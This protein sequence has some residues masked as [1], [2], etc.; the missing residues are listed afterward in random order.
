MV[1]GSTLPKTRLTIVFMLVI[2]SLAGSTVAYAQSDELR[3][4]Q[5]LW[6]EQ[7]RAEGIH[8][9]GETHSNSA[10]AA[11]WVIDFLGSRAAASRGRQEMEA[12][13][14]QWADSNP[15]APGRLY[16]ISTYQL[17]TPDSL[18]HPETVQVTPVAEGNVQEAVFRGANGPVLAAA[19]P[20]GELVNRA[21]VY[22]DKNGNAIVLDGETI[23]RNSS[24]DA[25]YAATLEAR[26]TADH[27]YEARQRQ[28]AQDIEEAQRRADQTRAEELARRKEE[29]KRRQEQE[30]R[31]RAL[32]DQ[33]ARDRE[34]RVAEDMDRFERITQGGQVSVAHCVEDSPCVAALAGH[35]PGT[36]RCLPCVARLRSA[37]VSRDTVGTAIEIRPSG[38]LGLGGNRLSDSSDGTTV[39]RLGRSSIL[40]DSRYGIAI[41]MR[42][43]D[44][45]P[46]SVIQ[47]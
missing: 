9:R 20:E 29:E 36:G 14:R 18:L 44:G 40:R 5:R 28:L 10:E 16:E 22:R 21:Y 3:R 35:G 26:E 15:T 46:G 11:G 1:V 45:G 6:E 25:D 8:E 24:Y 12:L 41:D 23:W 37:A 13:H 27:A 30:Q 2:A 43:L 39:L 31:A 17:S 42:G 4:L 38:P 19:P 32:H 33:D 47:P 34:R 7:Q